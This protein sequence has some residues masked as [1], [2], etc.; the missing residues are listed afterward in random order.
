MIKYINITA[1]I[2]DGDYVSEI[3][4]ITEEQLEII[5]PVVDAINKNKGRYETGDMSDKYDSKKLYGNL[6]GFK[7]F[8]KYVPFGNYGV[9]T[10]ES[11][12]IYNVESTE[13][14]M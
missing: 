9:H 2:N 14:L 11:V 4:T 8:R 12:V 1:D 7:T 10:I 6:E 3:G 13:K 5:K